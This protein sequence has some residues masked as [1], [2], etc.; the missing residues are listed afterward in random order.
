MTTLITRETTSGIGVTAKGSP[1][2]NAELDANFISLNDN[3][4]EKNSSVT[5]TTVTATTVNVQTLISAATIVAQ[6]VT[7][8]NINVQ[9][10]VSAATV[11]TQTLT[12]T[13]II[14]SSV[15]ALVFYG[16]G[17]K[18]TGVAT[19][20]GITSAAITAATTSTGAILR[21]TA[22]TS[23]TDVTL[24]A[25]S[26][27]TITQ[28]N[29]STIQIAAAATGGGS[30]TYATTPPGSPAVG[31]TWID[32]NTGNEYR[33]I[34]DGNSSQWVQTSTSSPVPASSVFVESIYTIT[35]AAGFEINPA[36][37]TIQLITLTASRTPKATNFTSA[38]T[39]TLMIDD[40]T[41]Y[42]ILW[43]DSTFGTGGVN[44]I[45]GSA[46][47]LATSGYTVIELWKIG[48][49]VYGAYVGATT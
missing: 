41:A 44:W 15:S 21:L 25:S 9:S 26:N 46:P 23:I 24:V 17:S 30:T 28:I 18:L 48:T 16:D 22:N 19:T 4:V 34:N 35:D 37:G 20:G 12:A 14:A 42:T 31:D 3:K 13:A 38:Q 43:T 10:T 47:A 33:Y 36:N 5:L 49:Q 8:V 2:S 1:L 11:V 7:S 27:I 6:S 39:V 45:G 32:S 40:G 29:S